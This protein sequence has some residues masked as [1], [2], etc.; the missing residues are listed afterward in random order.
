M[1][2]TSDANLLTDNNKL[3][4]SLSQVPKKLP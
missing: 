2:M 4:K 3:D 1:F